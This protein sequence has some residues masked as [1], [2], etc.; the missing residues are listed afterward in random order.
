MSTL[1][2]PQLESG[3]LSQYPIRKTK[4]LRTVINQAADGSTMRLADPA[5][6]L[7]EWRLAYAEL[8]DAEA[9]ALEAFFTAAEGTLN[10]FTFVDPA[11]NLLAWSGDFGNA[12]WQ[13]DPL[14]NLTSGA[15]DPAGGTLAWTLSNAGGA[16]QALGQTIEAPGGY[17]YCFSV[18]VRS[19]MP[20][21]VRLWIGS[22]VTERVVTSG[23]GRLVFA[24]APAASEVS[25]RF[26]VEAPGGTAV[27]VYGP[28]A[29]AQG[30]ASVYRQS[31]R[32]GVY[33]DAHLG[34]DVLRVTRT[35]FNR[36]SCTVN[37]IH[38]N[39]L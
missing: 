38:A 12:V 34:D 6:E 17:T 10:G 22:A 9:A 3:A 25:V 33:A 36:N 30:G 35:G 26:A 21:T 7:T 8:S 2:Y 23:W 1:V 19:A 14:L 15:A 28:Q 20:A 4:R 5:A 16:G 31:S 11:G 39:H 18:Y 37:I 27:D 13:K 24:A 32:G 29:E